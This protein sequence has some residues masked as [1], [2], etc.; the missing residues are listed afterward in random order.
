MDVL[1][2]KE[3]LVR[4]PFWEVQPSY[5]KEP[6]V[7][8]SKQNVSEPEDSNKYRIVTQAEFL[9]QLYPT[10][11]KINDPVLFPDVLKQDPETKK[12]YIQPITR[13]SFAMQQIFAIKQTVHLTGNDMQF[14]LAEKERTEGEDSDNTLLLDFKKGWLSKNMEMHFFDSV[15]SIKTTA[16]A[17]VVG[18]FDNKGKFGCKV[19]SYLKEDHLYPHYDSLTGELELFARKYFDYDENGE[20]VTEWVE[21]WDEKYLY[22]AKR[23]LSDHAIMTK[24]KDFFGMAGYTIV[25]QKPHGFNRIPV[26]YYR[27]EEGPCWLPAQDT[28][29]KYEEAYSYFFENNKAFAFPIMVLTGEGVE[30]QGDMNGSVKAITIEDG[31]GRAEFMQHNDV[32]T[33]Y[34]T[35]LNT[36]YERMYEQT[37]SVK[38]P[39]LK[40]GD[41]PGV[42]LK[43]LYSPAIEKA[44][45]DCQRLQP[46][47]EDL[48]YMVKYG[49]GLEINKQADLLNLEINAWIEPYVHQ[50]DTEL[51]TNLSTAVQNQF[52]SKQTATERLSKY[53]K[54][55]EIARIVRE[56]KEKM[57]LE[58]EKQ[59]LIKE[60][61]TDEEIRKNKALNKGQDVNTGG[62]T[63]SG[64]PNRSGQNWDEDGNYEGRNGWRRGE[65]YQR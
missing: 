16:D 20:Q 2:F 47:L 49:Y 29:E 57:L 28:I 56:Q 60:N 51:T 24:I 50:N 46:F 40:S 13:C 21:V 30:L 26:A 6:R 44:I 52:L 63:G 42:A 25:S 36:L 33:S 41:L 18:F 35:L 37:F 3:I 8:Y 55:D 11:H 5:E 7:V 45:I 12:W 1:D 38:P 17:A 23:G 64:R 31:D 43:L 59:D 58:V 48:V 15:Y 19:L 9:R 54:N 34:N 62:G 27:E 65:E 61:D 53:S 32:S 14:E 39:E 10:G 4:K 22:R